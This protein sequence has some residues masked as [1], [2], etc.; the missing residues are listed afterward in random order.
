KAPGSRV[1]NLES[2]IAKAEL[3]GRYRIEELYGLL[4][5][6]VDGFFPIKR[7]IQQDAAADSLLV[8]PQYDSQDFRFSASL[9][10]PV[11]LARIFL[12]ELQSLDTVSFLG[13]FNSAERL[14]EFK[15]RAPSLRYNGLQFDSILLSFQGDPE[16]LEGNLSFDGLL[17]DGQSVLA[18]SEATTRMFRDSLLFTVN[19]QDDTAGQKLALQ[20]L[21]AAS[22]SRYHLQLLNPLVLNGND[23]SIPENNDI[24]FSPSYLRVDGLKFARNR[25]VFR[26]QSREEADSTS[27]A[28]IDISFNQFRLVELSRL[29]GLEEEFL[30]GA[31]EGRVAI[32]RP[33]T[34]FVYEANLNISQLMIDSQEVGELK[35]YAAPSPGREELELSAQ[36][37]GRQNAFSLAGRYGLAN[38]QLGFNLRIGRLQMALADLFAGE[39]IS[40]SQGTLSARLEIG[41]TVN[42]PEIVGSV[43]LDSVSAFVK[44][45]QSRYIVPS[46]TIQLRENSIDI[47]RMELLDPDNR[48]AVLQGRVTHKYLED[49]RLDLNFSAPAFQVLNTGPEDNDLF[50]GKIMVSIDAGI[51]GPL[52]SPS[53]NV[54]TQTLPGTRLTAL[55]LSEEEAITQEGFIIYSKPS[56][57]QGDTSQAD[58]YQ[59]SVFGYDLSLQ[60]EL[61]PDAEL[62]AIIDPATGDQLTARGRANLLVEMDKSG[63]LSTTGDIS[64][65]DGAYFFNYEGLVKR[66][67]QIREGSRMFLPGDPLEARF[68]VSAQ[69][70]VR[71][72]TY[73]LISQQAGLSPQ[74]AKAARRRTE[75]QIIMNLKGTLSKPE[76]TFDIQLPDPQG[77]AVAATVENKLAQLRQSSNEL[78]KQVFGLL[79]FNSFIAEKSSSATLAE[80]GESI[81]LSSVSS[82]VTNQLN[83]LANQYVKGVDLEIRLDSYRA[84]SESG[85]ANTVTDIG[86][87]LSK[88]LF[89]DRLSVKVGGTVGLGEES[90]VEEFTTLASEFMLEY[91]LTE[92][93]RYRVRVF[94]RPDYDIIKTSN[95][96]RTGVSILYKKSFGGIQTIPDT[97][98]TR[99][100]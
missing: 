21:M 51:R 6:F 32:S 41:G 47:G 33:D 88:Q 46:H 86:L 66:T 82:L 91:K 89:N 67:F 53:I 83:R 56:E 35:L 26:V 62:T 44:Y 11:R 27:F 19:I 96:V 31:L 14:L 29:A 4:L 15:G 2:D 28:P 38:Q 3:E 79:I 65:T 45:L 24:A 76:I 69:Y 59:T 87:G 10:R 95:T 74:E 52:E 17:S 68:D 84:A 25:Q 30:S 77:S 7:F 100:R 13:K 54:Y 37:S 16:E 81:A 92:D 50:Y 80:T 12:P 49:I 99:E 34:T 57:F 72:S 1:V 18:Y 20:G 22:G 78:N 70:S 71:T 61:T 23:W 58:V 8:P 64:I 48:R 36:L 97:T 55:P 60:L 40:N 63:R 90:G 93:G 94:R 98:K 5:E 43:S 75:V 39:W 85:G 9:S 73:E 42:K